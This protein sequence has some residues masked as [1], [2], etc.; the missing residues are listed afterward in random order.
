MS[1]NVIATPDLVQEQ[2]RTKI[3]GLEDD[4]ED[5]MTKLGDGAEREKELKATVAKV[6]SKLSTLTSDRE[7]NLI[8]ENK[9]IKQANT[10]MKATLADDEQKKELAHE[11]LRTFLVARG[12]VE[13]P[14]DASTD[15]TTMKIEF[16]EILHDLSKNVFEYIFSDVT[17]GDFKRETVHK[18][19]GAE[20]ENDF[21]RGGKIMFWQ[22]VLEGGTKKI[23]YL[24]ELKDVSY[25]HKDSKDFVIELSSVNENDL[26]QEL[27]ENL[28]A[29]RPVGFN[30][31]IQ[32]ATFQGELRISDFEFG[33]AAVTLVGTLEA[34]DA[35]QSRTEAGYQENK[36]VD[37]SRGNLY[38]FGFKLKAPYGNRCVNMW[39]SWKQVEDPIHGKKQYVIGIVPMDQYPGKGFK[40]DIQLSKYVKADTIAA[41]N[42]DII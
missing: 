22:H 39:N 14:I 12:A 9:S 35:V 34:D 33:Q 23:D 32:K 19:E 8:N 5:L 27:L 18:Y 15:A 31:K 10:L 38:R 13:G 3:A 17:T 20:S 2:L 42:A 36:N 30:Q 40:E 24:I 11:K 37:K 4:I 28:D 26:Q 29:I 16:G 41:R 7:K 21:G 1:E 6:E 25:R